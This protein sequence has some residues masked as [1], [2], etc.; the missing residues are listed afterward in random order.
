MDILES[1]DIG[2]LLSISDPDIDGLD[3]VIGLYGAAPFAVEVPFVSGCWF[4]FTISAASFLS[5][6]VSLH[7]A[8]LLA[9]SSAINKLS[10][11]ASAI[12]SSIAYSAFDIRF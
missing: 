6:L 11:F 5:F 1:G 3:S 7:C 4:S 9:S 12:A 10:L 8:I 2:S